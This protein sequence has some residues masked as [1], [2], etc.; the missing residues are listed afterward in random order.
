MHGI[1]G[2]WGSLSAH[3]EFRRGLGVLG[4]VD[5]NEPDKGRHSLSS[6]FVS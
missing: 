5:W 3:R 1:V 6:A 2:L 4:I